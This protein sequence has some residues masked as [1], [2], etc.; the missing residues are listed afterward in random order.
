M[1]RPH[2]IF[3]NSNVPKPVDRGKGRV[4]KIDFGDKEEEIFRVW[5]GLPPNKLV[6]KWK[7]SG[8]KGSYIAGTPLARMNRIRKLIGYNGSNLAGRCSKCEDL[9]TYLVKYRTQGLR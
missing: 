6:E 2:R 8:V 3:N 1:P 4:E 9:N 7:E 5:K